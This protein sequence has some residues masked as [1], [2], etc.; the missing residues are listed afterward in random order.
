MDM[1]RVERIERSPG[2][3][4]GVVDRVGAALF[5]RVSQGKETGRIDGED[6]EKLSPMV[7][8]GW[9]IV[10]GIAVAFTL[11]GFFA[12]FVIGDKGPPDWDFGSLPDTPGL[13]SYST[14]PYRGRIEQPGAQHVNQ[15][16][17]GA[18][19][20]IS[21]EGPGSRRPAEIPE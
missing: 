8:H 1:D 7:F 3:W 9:L 6:E 2:L 5:A 14:Y 19:T 18:K 21:L 17:P 4:K 16:P 13:S 15:R 12:F 11:Y 20:D 10:C